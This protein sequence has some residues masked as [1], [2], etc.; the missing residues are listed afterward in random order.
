MLTIVIFCI[1]ELWPVWYVLDGS[2]VDIFFRE[3]VLINKKG[4]NVPLLTNEQRDAEDDDRDDKY[5]RLFS[6]T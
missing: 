4:I 3:D 5:S 6:I 2:F 1:V